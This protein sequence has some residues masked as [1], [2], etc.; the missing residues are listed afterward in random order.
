LEKSNS[1]LLQKIKSVTQKSK[2]SKGKKG[3]NED[4]TNYLSHIL[5]QS[6]KNKNNKQVDSDK[7]RNFNYD[8]SVL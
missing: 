1:K 4:L 2:S 8:L 3:S 5:K 7:V 6:S